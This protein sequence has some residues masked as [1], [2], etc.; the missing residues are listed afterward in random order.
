MYTQCGAQKRRIFGEM[1]NVKC[2]ANQSKHLENQI[3]E[4]NRESVGTREECDAPDADFLQID[5]YRRAFLRAL[6]H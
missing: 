5:A 2:V 4:L 3:L 6:L 1:G